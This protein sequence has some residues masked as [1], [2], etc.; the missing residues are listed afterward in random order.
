ML[1]L[2]LLTSGH[3]STSLIGTL[4][5]IRGCGALPIRGCGVLPIRGC[6][7]R[8]RSVVLQSWR[9]LPRHNTPV[10][11]LAMHYLLERNWCNKGN[12]HCC[13]QAFPMADSLS[14]THHIAPAVAWKIST[15]IIAFDVTFL[16]TFFNYVMRQC[17][18]R[19]GQRWKGGRAIRT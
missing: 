2:S 13:K 9:P 5:P 17:S 12:G 7:G 18:N 15:H 19:W 4:L 8:W 11:H 1:P 16:S 6:D 3:W 10:T 14:L